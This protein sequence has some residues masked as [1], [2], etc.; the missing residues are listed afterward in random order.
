MSFNRLSPLRLCQLWPLVAQFGTCCP[1]LPLC[2]SWSLCQLWHFVS[3]VLVFIRCP[4]E[5][6]STHIHMLNCCDGF[7]WVSSVS[8]IHRVIIWDHPFRSVALPVS[9]AT[10]LR[11]SILLLALFLDVLADECDGMF[12]SAETG[13]DLVSRDWPFLLILLLHRFE[14]DA[15]SRPAFVHNGRY[16]FHCQIINIA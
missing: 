4:L 5:F 12:A 7:V 9:L 13:Y 16:L 8:L 15:R 1:N 10:L 3:V 6:Y 2:S 14:L 11:Y